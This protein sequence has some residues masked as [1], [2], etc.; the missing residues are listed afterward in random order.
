[1]ILHHSSLNKA[2]KHMESIQNELG[3]VPFIPKGEEVTRKKCSHCGKDYSKES[4]RAFRDH[5]TACRGMCDGAVA[6]PTVFVKTVSGV[7]VEKPPAPFDASQSTTNGNKAVSNDSIRF[8]STF[9]AI[10]G[11]DSTSDTLFTLAIQ[12]CVDYGNLEPLDCRC[13]RQSI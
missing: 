12:C 5:I 8:Y 4:R 13:S 2:H 9:S 11:S 3:R 6:V 10:D 1:M 7:F